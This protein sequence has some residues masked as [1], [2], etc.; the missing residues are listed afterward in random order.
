MTLPITPDRRG[1]THPVIG[2][3]ANGVPLINITAPNRAGVSL[4]NFTQYNV[5]TN[6]AVIVNSGRPSASQL[7]GAVQGN[8]FLGNQSARVIIN[9]V[10][11]G[12]ATRLLGPTEIA[13]HRA[14]LVIA[15][16]AGITCAGCGFINTPRVSLST[17][18][19]T[20]NADGSLA[21][22]NV[23]QGHIDITG[24]GLDARGSALDLISRAM[25]INAQL[26]A[27]WAD[28]VAGANQVDYGTNAAH[29]QPGV[30]PAPYF[31]IDA[32]ALGSM[33]A[34][35][36]RLIGTEAGL[37]VRDVGG[38][39]SLTGEIH[40]SANGEI[41]IEPRARLQ[42]A[43]GTRIEGKVV[44]NRGEIVSAQAAALRA[45]AALSNE[46]VIAA[47]G[48][49][50]LEAAVLRNSAQV[51]A[52]VDSS[53]VLSAPGAVKL[54]ASEVVNR[55]LIAAGGGIDVVARERMSNVGGTLLANHA[56]IDA[57]RLDNTDGR[58]GTA[59]QLTIEVAHDISNAGGLIE[60]GKR[61]SLESETLSNTGGGQIRSVAGDL[62]IQAREDVNNTDGTMSAAGRLTLD[63]GVLRNERGAIG[64]G[65]AKVVADSIENDAGKIVAAG[66]LEVDARGAASNANGV[67]VGAS[68]LIFTA[69]RLLSNDHG[70]IG[71]I[72][73]DGS[74]EVAREID[75]SN[76][77]FGVGGELTLRAGAL[78]NG[79]GTITSGAAD[80]G[81]IG[82]LT[83]RG[84]TIATTRDTELTAGALRN[85][86]GMIGSV[87]GGLSVTTDGATN[88]TEGKLLADKDLSLKNAELDNRAG[89]IDADSVKLES[90]GTFNNTDGRVNAGQQVDVA[91]GALNN[92]G[93]LESAGNFT[94]STRGDFNNTGTMAAAGDL[95]ATTKGVHE[96]S[97]TLSA[98]HALSVSGATVNNKASGEML[99]ATQTNIKATDTVVNDGLIDGGATQVTANKTVLNVGRLYGDAVSIGAPTVVNKQNEQGVGGVIASR[100]DADIGAQSISN[101]QHALVH[102]SG[103]MRIGGALDADARAMGTAKTI[104]NDGAQLDAGGD[105]NID[106]DRVDNLN[107]DFRTAKETTDSGRKVWHQLPGSTEQI[108][109]S[110]VHLYHR[111]N[112]E[113]TEG[114]N[115]RWLGSDD[116]KVLLL[117]SKAYPAA[118]FGP[119]TVNGVAG[120]IDPVFSE[121]YWDNMSGWNMPP[122]YRVFGDNGIW[123]TFGIEAPAAMPDIEQR[124]GR[125]R[126]LPPLTG[127]AAITT[128]FA[129][130][131]PDCA[132]VIN[133]MRASGSAYTA[134]NRA[135]WKY[136][137]DVRRHMV[138]DWTIY[139]VQMRSSK[140][141]VVATQPGKI[142]AGGNIHINAKDG[143]N[144][145]S[146]IVAGGTAYLGGMRDNQRAVG[147]Q[148]FTA[149][150]HAI[151]TRVASGGRFSGDERK[152]DYTP[153][154]PAVPAREI[155]LP[156]A[157]PNAAR[158]A[159]IKQVV[160]RTP[161][162]PTFT[163]TVSTRGLDPALVTAVR[164]NAGDAVIRTVSPNV[165]LPSHALY[166][167]TPDA[168]SPFLI[169]TDPR[170]TRGKTEVSSD[171]ML[172]ALRTDPASVT[173]RIGDGFY[174]QQ[175]VLQQVMR[176]TG[177]YF[178]GDYTDKQRQYQALLANGVQAAKR[179]DL[180][181]GTALTEAQM[182]AL[183]TDMVWLVNQSVKL[184]DGT[185]QTVLAPQVYLRARAAD[186]T[187]EGAVIAGKRVRIDA[188]GSYRNSGT[189]AGRTVT[190]I[191]ADSI[192]NRG[193]VEADTVLIG[194]KRDFANLGGVIQGNAVALAAGR[195][196]NLTSTTRSAEADS[197][198][199]TGV[200]R[201][202]TINA[203]TLQVQAGHDVNARAAVMTT[204]GDAQIVAGNDINLLAARESS[205]EAIRWSERNRAEHAASVDVG[206]RIASGAG[207]TM[208]AGRDV[209]AVAAY[210]S[211]QGEIDVHAGRDVKLDAGKRSASALDEH[212]H[213][214][215]GFLSSKRTHTL[216]SSA[217][218]EAIGTTLSGDRV[219]VTASND[220]RTQAATI[221][222]TGD[223]TLAAGHD[224]SIGTAQ[225]SARE[226]HF[227]DVTRSGLGAAGAGISYGRSQTTDT[228]RDTVRSEQGSLVGSTHASVRMQAGNRLQI[229]GSDVIAG[230][231][232]TG[233]A[234][235]VSIEASSTQRH[236]DETHE[237]KSS[238]ISLAVK[239]PVID[240][241][242]NVNQQAQAASDSQDGR[243]AALRGIAAAGGAMEALIA[244]ED[245]VSAIKDPERRPEAKVELSVGASRSKMTF[246]EDST[247]HTGSHIRAGET[248]AFV[249]TGDAA[250]ESGNLTIAG[251][252]IDAREV[253]LQ[254][255]N[256]IDLL[257]SVDTNRTRSTNESKSASV[258]VSY[259]VDGVGVSGSV[260]YARGEANAD[261]SS[262]SNTHIN[263]SDRA[264]L[265]SGGDTNVV[266][267]NVNAKRIVA[268]IGGDLNIAS[269]QDTSRSAAH[270]YSGGGGFAVSTGGASGSFSVNAGQARGNYEAVNE[271]SGLQAG[272]GG[273]EV[274]VKGNTDLK[275]GYIASTASAPDNRLS[276]GTLSWSDV[277]NRSTYRATSGGMAQ[278]GTTGNGGNNYATHGASSGKNTGGVSPML[279]QH[280]SGSQSALTRSAVEAG[281]ITI[282]DEANQKQDVAMLNRDTSAL[283][284]TV[285]RTPDLQSKLNRQAEVMTAVQAAGEV[286]AKQIGRYANGK[287][288]AALEEMKQ[289]QARGDAKLAAHYEAQAERLS[290]GGKSRA[291]MQA[292]GAAVTVGLGGGNAVGAAAGAGVASLAG[293]KLDELAEQIRSS[294]LTGNADV[295]EAL[296]NIVAN[297]LATM[298]GAAVGGNA[299]AVGAYNVDRFNR[300]LRTDDREQRKEL[301]ALAEE[302]GLR[303]TEGDIANQQALMD[304]RVGGKAYYGDNQVATGEKP[305]D[306]T[307]WSY[308]AAFDLHTA[309]ERL[310]EIKF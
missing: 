197:G 157:T 277:M 193:M 307:D 83:N 168:G 24:A 59:G 20:L 62:R 309:N 137:D 92:D 51:W 26:W 250:S 8:P 235:E 55:G 179:F 78:E 77:R 187:G 46:G 206:T 301:T 155:E 205:E 66:A 305:Q 185:E 17:G 37:G 76:G 140:D 2:V 138:S 286:V 103:D 251:S 48:A 303:H 292:A 122:K 273:F 213:K 242:Q 3:S 14:N 40:L 38:I 295:D 263:A 162:V 93:T 44:T 163:S 61:L 296:G 174:E 41:T 239:T 45:S 64:G 67:I 1:P 275:G 218:T 9:Q 87:E 203:G 112:H 272:E 288:E 57:A 121:S 248:A 50:T 220:L 167:V 280:E 29:P 255:N 224:L 243:A 16:P 132:P 183:T 297:S 238:G 13:G 126:S 11:S 80:I 190:V 7:A 298:L 99:G 166:R 108:D 43:A 141:V 254:A 221:A 230:E 12:N 27:D 176:T 102:A 178:V 146:Q 268:D 152:N 23:T 124:D 293:G 58:I 81:V 236:H 107:A 79:A 219:T 209:N 264:T 287:R 95:R 256:R 100:G 127:S 116:H 260:S 120:A 283:S 171:T 181:V 105:A 109:P 195:D 186:V 123:R 73:G 56:T 98:G 161:D 97:G 75:N 232:I 300:Q 241:L 223:A 247:Q 165:Q 231:H 149:E 65:E 91:A 233:I 177:Q 244:T 130:T 6:G 74:F 52:G 271:Q 135:I 47:A 18:L 180:N 54:A 15:N 33:Y 4:N 86:H 246:T 253:L 270:Q 200:D 125:G 88:N 267:A 210:A 240:A 128:C 194:A 170:F 151:Y 21:G 71:T 189:I 131:A 94:L 262:H 229:T 147:E 22:L 5:G 158:A 36:V 89:D 281:S 169:Q 172:A 274:T 144:D 299:G 184:P 302:K 34:N 85:E 110:T 269:M 258:G 310:F 53:G 199:A 118:T 119:H 308:Y 198:T 285:A 265:V 191:T 215:S 204:T 188:A 28:A 289:A 114:A 142:T 234:R 225:N 84:G 306:G 182:A 160:A 106:A 216:D 214:E 154:R 228:S 279:V 150:G 129:S 237:M 143:S 257:S 249:A 139:D 117:P 60:G 101:G 164:A 192:T 19:P 201:L 284:G 156:V 113:I 266:G 212:Y 25:T 70:Q 294:K 68:S 259:G 82:E 278:G 208:Q 290:E 202:S 175:L 217:H 145:K 32:K 261:A 42:S 226:Y 39:T 49:V 30:G 282:T 173:K 10:T 69:G 148:T 63:A 207:L 134:L 104:T 90:A 136:N 111:N 291:L 222:S 252:D 227:K 196:V 211:A 115:Y 276:T 31:A 96:N 159:P 35:G 245:M 72:A 133:W 304:L 153:Y